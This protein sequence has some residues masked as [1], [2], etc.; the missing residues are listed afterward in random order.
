MID[1]L[2]ERQKGIQDFRDLLRKYNGVLVGDMGIN[3]AYRGFLKRNKIELESPTQE[4][5]EYENLINTSMPLMMESKK[6]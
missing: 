4:Q 2:T 3:K 5:Q 6:I 1:K